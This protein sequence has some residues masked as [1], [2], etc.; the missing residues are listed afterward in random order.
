MAQIDKAEFVTRMRHLLVTAQ[1]TGENPTS[2]R[3]LEE[4]LATA[5]ELLDDKPPP[6]AELLEMA[7]QAKQI[8]TE[9][10]QA[11]RP[12]A[13]MRSADERAAVAS[14]GED[15][16]ARLIDSMCLTWRHDFG[17]LPEAE[18]AGLRAQFQQIYQH[19]ILPLLTLRAGLP[20]SPSPA[21]L[22]KVLR[23]IVDGWPVGVTES[24][25]ITIH[26]PRYAEDNGENRYLLIDVLAIE[27][28]ARVLGI[29]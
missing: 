22:L 24:R 13:P 4:G 28:T 9:P 7:R 3:A 2:Q 8:P 14:K 6:N 27:A 17:L 5:L 15:L 25:F 29:R 23:L 12:A 16:P 19:D 10:G 18:K 1:A 11:A 21:L 26:N 20:P